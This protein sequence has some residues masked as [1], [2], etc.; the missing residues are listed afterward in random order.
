MPKP[1][2]GVNK[3]LS[4]T[5]FP[6][7]LSV[8]A[9]PVFPRTLALRPPTRPQR[10]LSIVK[11]HSA[12]RHP[13][14]SRPILCPPQPTH[15][16]PSVSPPNHSPPMRALAGSMVL[17]TP[18]FIPS[19]THNPSPQADAGTL[20]L[21]PRPRFL[22]GERMPRPMSTLIFLLQSNIRGRIM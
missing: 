3:P 7:L 16:T 17:S 4:A 11:T 15:S 22:L 2:K 18:P 20:P 19:L 12:P 6:M 10:L 1:W 14:P 13:P 9:R 5:Q 8:A 21:P